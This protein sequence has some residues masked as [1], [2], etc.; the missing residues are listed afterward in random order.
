M[1]NKKNKYTRKSNP[2]AIY[3]GNKSNIKGKLF[4]KTLQLFLIKAG[5]STDVTGLQVTLNK[6]SLHG[7]GSTY[8]PDFFKQFSLGIPFINPLMLV[9]E[10]KNYNKPIGLNLVRQFLGAF[11][12]VSQYVRVDTRKGGQ[13]RYDVLYD[14]RYNYC[15]VIFSLKGF[16]KQAKGLMFAHGINFIS[17]ENSEIMAKVLVLLDGLVEKLDFSKFQDTDFKLFED[18]AQIPNITVTAKRNGFETAYNNF[19]DYLNKVHSLIGVL[20]FKYPI[21]ILY[22][23]N[24]SA[25]YAR[26][27]RIIH[28]KDNLFILE[29]TARRKFGEF[30]YGRVFL[31]EYMAHAQKRGMLDKILT[32]IDVVQV[33]KGVLTLRKLKIDPTSRQEL[34]NELLNAPNETETPESIAESN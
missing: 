19:M 23:N 25:S 31:K 4:E 5:F 22:E 10:A 11:I 17:Y 7:R 2:L 29:N 16:H 15:P 20:D 34:I 24:V 3:S 33:T 18:L 26:D 27:V 28:K 12:D 14:T 32:E 9:M 21:H 6:K 1:A 13:Q 8:D 30:S